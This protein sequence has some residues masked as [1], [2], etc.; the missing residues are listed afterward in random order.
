M[1]GI[2]F[3][4]VLI[5]VI[6]TAVGRVIRRASEELAK[7]AERNAQGGMTPLERSIQRELQEK[8]LRPGSAAAPTAAAEAIERALAARRT[9]PVPVPP[10]VVQVPRP[11]TA[12]VPAPAMYQAP[13]PA[14]AAAKPAPKPTMT[15]RRQSVA[16]GR[17]QPRSLAAD[18]GGSGARKTTRPRLR[19]T[20]RTM[21][22][23]AVLSEIWQPPLA[24][25]REQ[26]WER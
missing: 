26:P 4:I 17:P 21:A 22:R 14:F 18:A 8:I 2:F 19:I 20:P 9:A 15:A 11:Q 3:I 5:I 10:V 7:V 16:T 12:P 23:I 6:I 13:K 25:R 24:L 1:D